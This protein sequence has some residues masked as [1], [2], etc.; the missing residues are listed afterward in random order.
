MRN[1]YLPQYVS[2]TS[3]LQ[4]HNN[5][6]SPTFNVASDRPMA[7]VGFARDII[8]ASARDAGLAEDLHHRHFPAQGVAH[9]ADARDALEWNDT[10]ALPRLRLREGQPGFVPCFRAFAQFDAGL[11]AAS[12]GPLRPQAQ[13]STELRR[14][15]APGQRSLAGLVPHH[16]PIE[17]CIAEIV[18]IRQIP[19]AQAATDTPLAV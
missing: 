11:P 14:R 3:V 15:G 9:R 13:L 17:F 16:R 8:L 1:R 18:R 6:L 12:K 7:V 10:P 5:A 2:E 4:Q 19:S